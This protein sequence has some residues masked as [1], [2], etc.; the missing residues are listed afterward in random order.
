MDSNKRSLAKTCTWMVITTLIGFIVVFLFIG[1]IDLTLY[2]VIVE[3]V[4]RMLAYYAHERFW[5]NKK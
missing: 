1:R 2:I 4:I 5:S 3:F